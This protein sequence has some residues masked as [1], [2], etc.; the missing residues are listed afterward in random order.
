MRRTNEEKNLLTRLKAGEFDGL[1]GDD[2]W[3]PGGSRVWTAIKDGIPARYKEGPGQRFF[4]GKENEHIPG[5]RHVL[6]EWVTDDDKIGF[7]R[8]LGFLIN[9]SAVKDYSAKYKPQK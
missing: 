2:L 7:L 4:N 6:Q 5:V 9:D 1:V 3:T 8:K